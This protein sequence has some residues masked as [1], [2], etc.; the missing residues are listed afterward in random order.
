MNHGIYKALKIIPN[1][2]KVKKIL[3]L[4]KKK[5]CMCGTTDLKRYLPK[6]DI[7]MSKKY[8]LKANYH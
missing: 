2:Q 5:N 7:K 3:T 1:N 6:E 8:L 4:K